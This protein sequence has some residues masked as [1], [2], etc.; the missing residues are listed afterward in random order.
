MKVGAQIALG[1]LIRHMCMQTL[2]LCATPSVFAIT[3][4][5]F[6]V[7]DTSNFPISP[8]S[9]VTITGIRFAVLVYSGT[10]IVRDE[11]GL[12]CFCKFCES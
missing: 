6:P 1:D 9:R 4:K 2:R 12:H 5:R 11:S 3:A 8:F 10:S 7:I